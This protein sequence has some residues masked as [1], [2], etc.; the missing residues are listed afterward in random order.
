ML[1]HLIVLGLLGAPNDGSDI[2]AVIATPDR[3]ASMLVIQAT[4]SRPT[5]IPLGAAAWPQPYDP[6][7]HAPYAI[8]FADLLDEGEK[9]AKIEAIKV[10]PAAVLLGISV[11]EASGYGPII[12][13]AGEK[14]QLWF[15][16][17]QAY[18][19]SASFASAGV[20]LPFTVRVLTDSVPPKRYERTAVLTVRQL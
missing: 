18:W 2:G 4:A 6:G 16:V 11:D 9:I 15:L 7:D 12:D 19:E 13:V 1:S 14:I 20:L 5:S 3:T 17:D 8:N 10:A